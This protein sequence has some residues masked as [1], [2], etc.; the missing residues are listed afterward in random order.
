MVV[1]TLVIGKR[2]NFWSRVYVKNSAHES[3]EERKR[4]VSG[5]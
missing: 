1:D 5:L 2:S 3:K 4:D